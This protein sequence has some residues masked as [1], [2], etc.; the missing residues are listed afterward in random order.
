MKLENLDLPEKIKQDYLD[1]GIEVLNPPQQKAVE[2]GLME[3]EDL[4]IASPTASGKTFIAELGIVNQVVKNKGK[5]VYI[6]PLKALAS[7]KYEDFT[8]RY[9]DLNV[10]MSVGDKDES[11]DYLET[12]DIVIVTS[13]KLDSLLRHNPSWIHDINLVVTDEIHLLTSPNRGPTL[14]ITLTRLRDILDFQL[15]GLS[16]TISNSNELADWLD[17]ATDQ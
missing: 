3:E 4:I 10:M 14:E 9:E 16:A 17:Q 8:E 2:N 7:E 13:E 15:L 6:V 11:G 5:A 12:A 1:S